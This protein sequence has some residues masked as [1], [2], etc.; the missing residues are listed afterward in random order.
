[1]KI[2][3]L[4]TRSEAGGGQS[5]VAVLA[6]ELAARGH[7]VLVASGSEGGGEAWAGLDP[8]VRIHFIPDLVRSISPSRDIAARAAIRKL[9]REWQPD[10]AHLHT[11]KAAALGRLAGGI[12]GARIVYTMHGY[13]QIAKLN[14]KFLVIDKMLKTRCGAIVAVSARDEEAMRA[15][16]YS[17]LCIP[18]G[19]ADM[20]AIAPPSTPASCALAEI[21]AKGLPLALMVARDAPPKRPDLVRAAARNLPSV[22]SVAWI[23]GAP[24][25]GDPDNFYALGAVPDAGSYLALADFL[26]LPSDNEGMPMSILEAFSAG[27]PVVASKVGGIARML[28]ARGADEAGC[29]IAVENSVEDMTAAMSALA[30]DSLLR[31]RMG[32]AARD[33][34]RA[35]Y[36]AARMT[37]EYER[38]YNRLMSR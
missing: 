14:K 1:M 21:R 36:S 15:D 19:V 4:I 6:N 28:T 34:W 38:L 8:R 35:E 13:D 16:G 10:I 5:V 25:Q 33:A 23:G 32:N 31:E 30:T 17:P 18:N 26:V 9:Y 11:S 12:R 2:L 7:E 29:G 24:E 27:R 37:D 22:L 3:Q 20:A